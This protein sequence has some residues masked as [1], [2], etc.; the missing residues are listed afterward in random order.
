MLILMPLPLIYVMYVMWLVSFTGLP[1][2]DF[3]SYP[4]KELVCPSI[5]N[6]KERTVSL[7]L[8][9]DCLQSVLKKRILPKK[10]LTWMKRME[11]EI[12]SL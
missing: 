6:R 2:K 4:N 10:K 11:K 3:H 1:I 8:E 9:F 12:V 7:I 5:E